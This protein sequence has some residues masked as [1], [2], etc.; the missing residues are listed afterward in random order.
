MTDLLQQREA[1]SKKFHEVELLIHRTCQD[2]RLQF[3]GNYED[4]FSMAQEIFLIACQD[5]DETKGAKFSTYCRNM[6]WFRLQDANRVIQNRLKIIP[7]VDSSEMDSTET[8]TTSDFDLMEFIDE[9]NLSSEAK[10]VIRIAIHN[11]KVPS[12]VRD[13]QAAIRK[14]LVGRGWKSAA[15]SIVFDEIKSALG[16]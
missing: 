13:G 3:G 9:S 12:S 10:T 6:I 15:V 7:R 4:L 14:I 5:Y 2:F 1:T 8:L 16:Y 11:K